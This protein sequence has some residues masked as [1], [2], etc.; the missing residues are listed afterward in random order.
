MT[1]T[2]AAGTTQS[3][4]GQ[5]S[6]LRTTYPNWDSPP[7]R[8]VPQGTGT[9]HLAWDSSL[10]SGMTHSWDTPAKLGHPS[11]NGTTQPNWDS[12]PTWDVP[13]RVGRLN[14]L[15]RPM[16]EWDDPAVGHPTPSPGHTTQAGTS[17]TNWSIPSFS[18][19]L[20]PLRDALSGAWGVGDCVTL[21]DA[22]PVLAPRT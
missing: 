5:P 8:D 2:P 1:R 7:T 10:Q 19:L 21:R 14:R 9:A 15:G 4:L 22:V 16:K 20:S 13:H 12:P 18:R 11:Q 6:K 3:K 17:H